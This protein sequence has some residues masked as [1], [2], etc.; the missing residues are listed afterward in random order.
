MVSRADARDARRPLLAGRAATP[1][2]GSVHACGRL[3]ARVAAAARTASRRGSR[4]RALRRAAASRRCRFRHLSWVKP[5][6]TSTGR[7]SRFARA[8]LRLTQ[9]FNITGHPAMAAAGG[10]DERRMAG[11]RAAR[12]PFGRHTPA[13]P[14]RRDRRALQHRRRGI[15][16]RWHRMNVRLI[17]R[18]RVARWHRH[19]RRW[20]DG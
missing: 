2:N 11:Q 20:Q 12:R 5:R 8:M 13:D 19:L 6:S 7:R 16:W 10:H 4:A 14:G 1:G 18:R 9:L 15:G 17:F 3:R